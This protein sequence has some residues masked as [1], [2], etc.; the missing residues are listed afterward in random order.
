MKGGGCPS[1]GMYSSIK[2]VEGKFLR[3]YVHFMDPRYKNKPTQFWE[4]TIQLQVV[5]LLFQVV[6][7]GLTKRVALRYCLATTALCLAAPLPG[8]ELTTWTF[9]AGEDRGR[10]VGGRERVE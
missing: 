4:N 6:N 3:Y 5:C 8:I 10:E 1:K 2:I 9:A 7:P